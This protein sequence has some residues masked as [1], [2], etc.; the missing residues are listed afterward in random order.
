MKVEFNKTIKSLKK[1]QAEMKLEMKGSACHTK[2]QRQ[3][4]PTQ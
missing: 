2:P 4:S 3:A 1:I